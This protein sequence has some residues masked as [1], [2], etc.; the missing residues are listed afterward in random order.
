MLTSIPEVSY[1]TGVAVPLT[2]RASVLF[3]SCVSS[4][5]NR[6]HAAKWVAS[7]PLSPKRFY[8]EDLV[9]HVALAA[10]V[11]LMMSMVLANPAMLPKH[12]GY[13]MDNAINPVNGQSLANDPPAQCQRKRRFD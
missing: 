11:L 8:H 10:I 1:A 6:C 13:S 5:T 12:P 7:P 3:P 2:V 9:H 4:H